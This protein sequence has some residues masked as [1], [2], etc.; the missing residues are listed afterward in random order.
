MSWDGSSLV[1]ANCG[2]TA[3]HT[4]CRRAEECSAFRNLSQK[5]NARSTVY[6]GLQ[7]A[8]PQHRATAVK[9]NESVDPNGKVAQVQWSWL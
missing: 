8:T 9:P 3:A 7:R 2:R 6:K 5:N 4:L 1:C